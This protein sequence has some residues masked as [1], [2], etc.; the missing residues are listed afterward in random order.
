MAGSSQQLE[1]LQSRIDE[2][3]ELEPQVGFFKESLPRQEEKVNSVTSCI[4]DMISAIMSRLQSR[5]EAGTAATS[6][7]ASLRNTRDA[8]VGHGVDRLGFGNPT[9]QAGE[10]GTSVARA[11]R[12]RE[13]RGELPLTTGS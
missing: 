9:P 11:Y 12:R 2:F 6:E 1:E 3:E 4:K 13:S 10:L 8:G 7:G 5:P